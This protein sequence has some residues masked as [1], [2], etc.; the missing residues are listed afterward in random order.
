MSKKSKARALRQSDTRRA[1]L[2]KRL[3][4]MTDDLRVADEGTRALSEL[5]TA[6]I[7]HVLHHAG[8]H[9]ISVPE[10]DAAAIMQAYDLRVRRE[11]G[12]MLRIRVVEKEAE[13]EEQE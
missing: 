10:V 2:E 5:C 13:K 9:D 6:T 3:R 4:Q 8:I 1:Q 11:A 12:H 7:L